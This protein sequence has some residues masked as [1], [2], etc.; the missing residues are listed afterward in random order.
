MS[1]PAIDLIQPGDPRL[2]PSK[3]VGDAWALI[4]QVDGLELRATRAK[5]RDLVESVAAPADRSSRP[6]HLTGSA[7][8][9]DSTITTTLLLFHTKLRIWV[10]PGGHADGDCNLASVAL[11]E[12]TEETGISGLRILPNPIDI[13]IHEVAPPSED[14]HFHHD[15]RFLVVAPPDGEFVGNHE[16]LDHR[17]LPLNDLSSI[18]ADPGVVRLCAR[19]RTLSRGLPDVG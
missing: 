12:A 13:D 9:V 15:V 16:S 18:S 10:Q 6:G 19:A 17:W 4:S 3:R 1:V 11:R 7:L 5:M 2:Q 8:V 14:A